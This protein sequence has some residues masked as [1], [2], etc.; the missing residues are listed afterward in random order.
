V[1]ECLG[2]AT[3]LEEKDLRLNYQ[4][5]AHRGRGMGGQGVALVWTAGRAM[6]G[7]KR[8][9]AVGDGRQRLV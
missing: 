2:G 8:L 1:T 5:C 3:R 6:A 9:A 4:V 7:T